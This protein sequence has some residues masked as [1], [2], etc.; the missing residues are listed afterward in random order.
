[1]AKISLTTRHD[2]IGFAVAFADRSKASV[3]W[4]WGGGEKIKVVPED[5]ESERTFSIILYEA[6]ER[7]RLKD[8]PYKDYDGV[9]KV[10]E[11]VAADAKTM[12]DFLAAFAEGLGV[13]GRLPK[14]DPG[15]AADGTVAT[16]KPSR[17][18][19]VI[20][21]VFPTGERVELTLNRSSVSQRMKPTVTAYQQELSE[22][23]F[24][25]MGAKMLEPK[26]IAEAF[27]SS[28]EASGS[29]AEWID[30]ARQ[31]IFAPPAMKM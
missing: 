13:T 6:G 20:T 2:V 24:A 14:L 12:A 31:A 5:R 8:A 29:V 10:A 28:A 30:A 25:A 11:K 27:R 7:I 1:M 23:A 18:G 22:L 17:N 21:C 9:R 19:H 26:D 16:S 4:S 15:P 3:T